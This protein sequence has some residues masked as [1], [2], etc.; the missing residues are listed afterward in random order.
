MR[1]GRDLATVLGVGLVVRAVLLP[2]GHGEDFV[3]W[4]RASAALLRGSN[5]Y[6]HHP[7]FPHGP[8]AY[9]PLFIYLDA[10]FRWLATHTG[11]SFVVLGKLPIVAADVACALLL[12]ALLD[13]HGRSPRIAA[14]G[15]ALYFVNPLVLY[16]SAFYGRF[17]SLGCALLLVALTAV[18]VLPR[19]GA[20][21]R[22]GD[23]RARTWVAALWF[24][25]AVAAKTFPGF[26]AFGV[27][28]RSPDRW[29]LL[30]GTA[31]VLVVVSAPFLGTPFPFVHDLAL[32]DVGKVPSGLSW[33]YLLLKPLGTVGSTIFSVVLLGVFVAAA[34]LLA[35]RVQDL[36]WYTAL[37]L[38]LFMLCSKLV[39][40][41]YLTWPMPW[42]ILLGLTVPGR[43]GRSCLLTVAGFT[44][45]GLVE[46]EHWHP[47][48]RP[49]LVVNAIFV[50]VAV[51]FLVVGIRAARTVPDRPEP[52]V[53]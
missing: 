35:Q 18:D 44:A 45:V 38:T 2:L 8:Y 10:P 21:A 34:A 53:P 20:D 33:Q 19:A 49:S 6:A 50:V 12:A 46:N 13:R 51:R 4:D 48:G 14:A 25:L 28:R 11:A 23:V 42:L 52:A 47:L 1:I 16:N 22:A 7:G 3:V 26:V 43:A 37:T 32:R 29:R 36:W 5:F 41:Q 27:L 31:A 24:G 30:L 9:F 17:D 40:E 39:L 15:A